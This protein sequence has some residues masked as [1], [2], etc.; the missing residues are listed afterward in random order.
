MDTAHIKSHHTLFL[1]VCVFLGVLTTLLHYSFG[2][3]DHIEQ[4]PIIYR[5]LDPDYLTNDFFVNSNAEFSPR[6]Y[7]AQVVSFFGSWMGIPLFFL[8]GTLL[9]NSAIAVL[10]YLNARILLKN[11]KT[12]IIAAAFVMVFPTIHLGGDLV[13]FGSMFTPTTLVFPFVLLAFY[14]FLQKRMVLCFMTTGAISLVHILIGL[15]Y[16]ILFLFTWMLVDFLQNKSATSFLKKLPYLAIIIVFLLPN[17]I[18]Y[19]ENKT[20][21][22]SSLFIEMLAHF[23]HP[24]HYV[25]SEILT[26]WEVLKLGTVIAI[27]LITWKTFTKKVQN[28]THSKSVQIIGI[29]LVG[30]VFLNWIFIEWIPIK[31]VTSL[32]LLRLLNFGKWIF[33]L[34][35]VNF[36]YQRIT[37]KANKSDD[38]VVYVLFIFLL[39]ISG[40]SMLKLPIIT[41]TFTFVLYLLFKQKKQLLLI[42]LPLI[43]TGLLLLNYAPI[44]FLKPYQKQYL[45]TGG[46]TETQQELS[47]FVQ[48]N[49]AEDAIFLSPPLFGFLRTEAKRAIVVDFKA[50]PFQE[51]A[52]Q[53]WYQR[54]EDCYGLDTDLLDA[55]YQDM[56][57]AK[58]IQ[59]QH[60][61]GFNY[62]VLHAKT[63]TKIPTIYSNSEYK[64]IALATYAQ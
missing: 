47:Q 8:I 56:T 27:V 43:L 23:R 24:H 17:L 19:F 49:T 28:T 4:L 61:Y 18:P 39:S 21:I 9:S 30:A 51:A 40:V 52:M 38:L 54:I 34:L 1:V 62:A 63:E 7:Y 6:Y 5:T 32:Q 10:T 45:S 25:L 41:V 37:G 12:G 29:L 60:K 36:M 42:S 15:E 14:F 48:S 33:I 53:E 50:F 3:N 44:S 13:L 20:L 46:L 59:L 31:E 55:V 22:D 11:Q 35:F 16:G 64:I 26:L 2:N 57:D 58:V